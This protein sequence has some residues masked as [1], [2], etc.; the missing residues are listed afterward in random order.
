M[1]ANTQMFALNL[2]FPDVCNTPVGPVVVPIPYPN[3]A[4]TAT[5]IPNV[6]NQFIM[7]MPIHNLMTK[8]PMSEGDEPGVLLGIASGLVMG[9]VQHLFGS[10]KVFR[11]VMPATKM[12]SPTGHN[13]F[14]LNIPG[15]TLTPSQIKVLYFS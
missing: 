13:G 5:A 7:A 6:F 3:L 8:V 10:V 9:P 12:L 1:F 4:P 14:S 15:L 11:C 2:G